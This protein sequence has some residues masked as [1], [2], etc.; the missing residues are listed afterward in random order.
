MQHRSSCRIGP[1]SPN[2]CSTRV[3][4]LAQAGFLNTVLTKAVVPPTEAGP[5]NALIPASEEDPDMLNS[6]LARS[7][8]RVSR[9]AQMDPEEGC[10][11]RTGFLRKTQIQGGS[12]GQLGGSPAATPP[13]PTPNSTS[14]SDRR[15]QRAATMWQLRR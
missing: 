11:V 5:S 1:K 7:L 3:V 9:H 8:Y 6:T 4:E 2:H 10:A 14:S 13:P 15:M 12:D